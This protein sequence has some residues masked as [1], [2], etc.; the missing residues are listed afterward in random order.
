MRPYE[1]HSC[2]WLLP[3]VIFRF[4]GWNHICDSCLP[5]FHSEDLVPLVG[6]CFSKVAT[7]VIISLI[8]M[9]VSWVPRRF[10]WSLLDLTEERF[11]SRIEV[12][13]T[14]FLLVSFVSDE[15]L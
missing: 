4:A 9:I 1:L 11:E 15:I 2:N 10:L 14:E 12:N 6:L 7:V 8:L 5:R 3:K 13:H